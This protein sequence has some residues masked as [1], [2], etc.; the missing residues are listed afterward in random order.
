MHQLE[1]YKPFYLKTL[2]K[3]TKRIDIYFKK[4]TLAV[5]K[6]YGPFQNGQCEKSCEIKGGTQ[7]MVVM[8]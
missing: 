3:I 7:E 5:K 1:S 6:G 4:N 2:A 8:E